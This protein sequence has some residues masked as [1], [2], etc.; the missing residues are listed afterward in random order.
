MKTDVKGKRNV[1]FQA[2]VLI[3]S[4]LIVCVMAGA[5]G[6]FWYRQTSRQAQNAAERY[7]GSVLERLNGS[8]ETMLRDVDHLVICAS[9][10]TNHI[11]SPLRSYET[12]DPAEKL[13]YNQ[14]ILDT[15]LS[16]YQFKTYLEGM[17]ISSTTGNY[18]RIGTTLPYNTLIEQPWFYEVSMEDKKSAVI[19]PYSNGSEMVLSIARNIYSGNERLGVVKADVRY[20]ILNDCYGK[21]FNGLGA[22]YIID[23]ASGS[24]I[25]PLDVPQQ[26]GTQLLASSGQSE[27]SGSCYTEIAGVSSLVIYQRSELTGWLTLGVVPENDVTREFRGVSLTAVAVSLLFGVIAVAFLA[28]FLFSETAKIQKLCTAVAQIDG[29]NLQMQPV[30][31][32]GD[33]IETL[34]AQIINMVDRIRNLLYDI[35]R[36]EQTR[37][38]MEFQILQNQINPHFLHNTLNTIRYMAYVQKEENIVNVVDSLSVLLRNNMRANEYLTIEEEAQSLRSYLEIQ[39]FKYSGKYVYT[40]EVEPGLEQ[41]GILKM[42]IQPLVENALKHGIA[43]SDRPGFIKVQMFLDDRMLR[44]EVVDNGVGMPQEVIE[45]VLSESGDSHIGLRNVIDRIKIYYGAPYGVEIHSGGIGTRVTL[46]LP[47]MK[48]T[49]EMEAAEHV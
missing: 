43:P 24:I 36:A 7:I 9:I 42:L 45:K 25:Y 37:H 48:M 15:M 14:T 13:A 44:V 1:H 46:L 11:I 8:F 18:F 35:Q 38:K 12:A 40:V 23:P 32:S 33:E 28:A 39:T 3:V 47:K 19:L 41:Y 5:I 29:Q 26:I 31:H 49:K 34:Q 21:D 16:L 6:G 2:K 20:T 10:D 27:A 17:M 22:I 30:I 4:V